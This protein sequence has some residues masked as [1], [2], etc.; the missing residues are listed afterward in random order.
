[1]THGL[2]IPSISPRNSLSPLRGCNGI[3]AVSLPTACAVG[4]YLSP[5]R[6]CAVCFA[7]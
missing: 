1:M 6:G 3:V 7:N 4:Y 2:M 5:L